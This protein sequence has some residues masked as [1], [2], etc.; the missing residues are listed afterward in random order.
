MAKIL[1]A[2]DDIMTANMISDL[3][4]SLG[5][6][7]EVVYTGDDGLDRLKF[8][9]FD[10]AILDWQ[11]PGM[12]GVDVCK[13][14]RQGGGRAPILML[15]GK[16]TIADKEHGFTSGADDYL[17]KPFD[18]RELS[19]RIKALLRRPAD[20]VEPSKT[21]EAGMSL[22]YQNHCLIK[23]GESFSLLPKEFAVLEFL[24]RHP[25]Q[26]FTPEVLLNKVWPSESEATLEALRTCIKRI[27]K[28][29]DPE[30]GPSLISTVR[31]YGYKLDLDAVTQP[32]VDR[33]EA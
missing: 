23:N 5:H 26:Y 4:K 9:E 2:E 25:N 13:Q 21:N 22:D 1:I 15:T 3:V 29:V 10:L 18:V 19:A 28:K 17:T 11:M 14:Y 7:S 12:S 6:T 32:R 30:Q 31:G 8:Y 27:R 33:D 16:G 20:Y 24:L